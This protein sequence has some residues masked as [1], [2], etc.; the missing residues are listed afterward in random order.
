MQWSLFGRRGSRFR[1]GGRLELYV[2]A[3][4]FAAGA[5][6]VADVDSLLVG[7]QVSDLLLDRVADRLLDGVVLV[8]QGIAGHD[9]GGHVEDVRLRL[10]RVFLL[11]VVSHPAAPDP[12]I[13]ETGILCRP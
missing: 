13:D 9:V 10:D 2:D 3:G 8:E 1:L 4:L 11:V 12:R 7:E 6:P 5:G